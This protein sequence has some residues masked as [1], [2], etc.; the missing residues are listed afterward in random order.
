M[1]LQVI[2]VAYSAIIQAKSENRFD[3]IAKDWIGTEKSI[4][5]ASG[6]SRGKPLV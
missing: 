5:S 1:M 3:S 2:S 4:A 6:G